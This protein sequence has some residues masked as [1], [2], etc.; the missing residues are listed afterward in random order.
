MPAH[1]EP[2][3]AI[4]AG[5]TAMVRSV[6]AT[7]HGGAF[8]VYLLSDT[9][10]PAVA[11]A[12]EAAWLDTRERLQGEIG[13]Y[14]RRRPS[15]VGRK[16]GNIAD[17][18]RR[19]GAGYDF[20]VV[21]D[22][23]SVMSG[24]TVVE[25]VRLME[26]NP[27]A[28]LIQTVPVPARQETRF[29]RLIQF[30]AQLSSRMLAAGQSFWQGDV[31]NYWGHN[32]IVRV[33]AFTEHCSLPVLAGRP[34]LGGAILSHD[35]VEAALLRRAGWAVYLEPWLEG[36]HE[37][38]PSN[39]LDFAKRDR[40]WAQGSLQHLCLLRVPGLHPLSRLHFLLGAMG[41]VSSVL[42][43]GLLMASTAYVVFPGL[44]A[45]DAGSASGAGSAALH[46]LRLEGTRFVP[47]LAVTAVVLFLPKILALALGVVR[48]AP[49]FGGRRRLVLGWWVETWFSVA[50]APLMMMFHTRAVAS[51]LS[52]RDV[53]WVAQPREGRHVGWAEAWRGAAT[54]TVVGV[55][56]AA[57]TLA[58]SPAFFL[59]LTPIF[60]GLV[61]SAPLIRATGSPSR[62]WHARGGS[63]LAVPTETRTPPELRPV[64]L[65][66]L[67]RRAGAGAGAERRAPS[68]AAAAVLAGQVGDQGR[69]VPDEAD[70]GGAYEAAGIGSADA[71][72]LA[73]G[74]EQLVWVPPEFPCE[75]S[76][77]APDATPR[78]KRAKGRR[79][80]AEASAPSA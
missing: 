38:V 57:L 8:D 77:E 67:P 24:T 62:V 65:D 58:L 52:G 4:M 29:G 36:S 26:A 32:A 45:G 78:T 22:A 25:L 48:H 69:A 17:F 66:E 23:D 7:G 75:M 30:G 61:L 28:G 5:L 71:V 2:P 68:Y 12:E 16:A 9:T 79:A 21:L 15:N 63:L 3:N 18:C 42:W 64:R 56:W 37:G 74:S 39:I 34:P 19:W 6:E 50:V 73:P 47:L 31:A 76:D 33:R 43:L 35:F 80:P 11:L 10:D 59:W 70:E 51:V 40:R 49:D 41:Y 54:F 20:M 60:A 27:G 46:A 1:N 14:Y 55:L 53:R 72:A 44:G 13:L